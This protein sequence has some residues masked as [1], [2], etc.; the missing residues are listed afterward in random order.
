[1]PKSGWKVYLSAED[2]PAYYFSSNVWEK[3]PYVLRKFNQN[4][5]PEP[6]IMSFSG[7]LVMVH[8]VL[9]KPN[10]GYLAN[11]TGWVQN[12]SIGGYSSY[13]SKWTIEF[14]GS[15]TASWFRYGSIPYN[16]TKGGNDGGKKIKLKSNTNGNYFGLRHSSGTTWVIRRDRGWYLRWITEL[17]IQ[18]WLCCARL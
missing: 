14:G 17:R 8:I 6:W 10:G 12:I 18:L 13:W 16:Q 7:S 1:M 9:Q 4:P 15:M 3:G 11:N 2:W 5:G